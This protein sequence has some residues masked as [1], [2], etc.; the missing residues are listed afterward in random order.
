MSGGGQG[1]VCT[2]VCVYLHVLYVWYVHG[3]YMC[4]GPQVS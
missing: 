1:A 2:C 3:V 4:T